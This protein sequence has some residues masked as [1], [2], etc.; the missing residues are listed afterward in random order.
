[1][2]MTIKEMI[3]HATVYVP[4][5]CEGIRINNC[6]EESFT[7]TGEESG[8]EYSVEYDEVDITGGDTIYRLVLMTPEDI[9]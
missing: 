3:Q 8:E 4:F 7:G 5:N 9:I 2:A 1:M 6:D